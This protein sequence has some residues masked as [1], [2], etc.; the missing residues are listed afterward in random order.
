MFAAIPSPP[1]SGIHIGPL[2]VHAYGLAYI[3]AVIAAVAV[4]SHRWERQ[5]GSRELV[6]EVALW[7]LLLV[8]AGAPMYVW[9][10]RRR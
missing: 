2:F 5:G 1:S 8:I 7:G 3:V 6:H 10:A 4:V 9:F